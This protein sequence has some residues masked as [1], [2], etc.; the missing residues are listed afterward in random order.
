MSIFSEA[1]KTYDLL[2][3]KVGVY[4]GKQPLL[5]ICHTLANAT[6]EIT[7]DANGEFVKADKLQ[8]V[9]RKNEKDKIEDSQKVIIPGTERSM[10]RSSGVV[11]HPLIDSGEYICDRNK[12]KHKSYLEEL[13]KWKDSANGDIKLDIIYRYVSTHDIVNDIKDIIGVDILSDGGKLDDWL[14]HNIITWSVIGIGDRSGSVHK[15]RVLQNKFINY[16]LNTIK[17]ERGERLCMVTG[18]ITPPAVQHKRGV[19]PSYNKARLI[20]ANDSIGYTYR[21]RFG[22]DPDEAKDNSCT[23]GFVASQK[24][25]NM[26]AYLTANYGQYIGGDVYICWESD[27]KTYNI[28]GYNFDDSPEL[29]EHG[30][31]TRNIVNGGKDF[32]ELESKTV[33]LARFSCATSGRLSVTMY[34]EM[35]KPQFISR[36]NKWNSECSYADWKGNIKTPTARKIVKCAFGENASDKLVGMEVRKLISCKLNGLPMPREFVKKLVEKA[37]NLQARENVGEL[38]SVTYAVLRKYIIDHEKEDIGMSLDK[39]R[40]DYSYQYGRLMAVLEKA[41]TDTYK[42]EKRTANIIKRQMAFTKTPLTTTRQVTEQLKGAYYPKLN[43]GSRV[44]YDKLIGE[45]MNKISECTDNP[46]QKLSDTYIIGYY[47]QK[48]ALYAKKE[49]E[50]VEDEN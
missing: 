21:G 40:N 2:S 46:N 6:V 31:E 22:V 17:E 44:Y 4:E 38:L 33:T 47:N 28:D 39:E 32:G 30:A 45:I 35:T 23:I 5:P 43:P 37:N 25:H 16:Y 3:D 19:V 49:N 11:A 36:M 10:G 14:K 18:E 20:S 9:V 50:N 24:A 13:G 12:E 41:E 26:L 34:C 8:T 7:L 27:G 15:D 48:Q 42:N 29:T 1:I